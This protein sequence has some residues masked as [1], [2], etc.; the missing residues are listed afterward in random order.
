MIQKQCNP[1]NMWGNVLGTNQ[2]SVE[3]GHLNVNILQQVSP[4]S[5]W[6]KQK[7]N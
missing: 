7:K 2:L 4:D 5:Y 6:L 1:Y 3:N